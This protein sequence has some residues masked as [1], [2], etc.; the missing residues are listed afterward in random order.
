MGLERAIADLGARLREEFSAQRAEFL[1]LSRGQREELSQALHQSTQAADFKLEAIRSTLLSRLAALETHNS[2]QLEAMRAV[3]DEKL[4]HTLEKRLGDS[5]RLVSERLD[6]V[7]KGLGEM[8]GLASG[9][10][11]LRRLL[12][13]V[14]TRGTWGEFQLAAIL[15]Q[16]LTPE[17]YEANVAVQTG[18]AERVEF[19]IRLPGKGAHA[20]APVLL[21]IDSKF[22]KEDYERLLAAQ[23]AIDPVAVEAASRA[24]EQAVRLAAKNIRTQYIHPPTTTDF[25]IL[26]LPTESLYAEVLRR[27][28]LAEAMQRDYRIALAGPTTLAALLNSLQMGFRTLAIEERSSEVWAILGAVKSEF[29]K[30]GDILEKVQDKL[31]QASSTIE[32]ATKKTRT[33]VRKLR[34]VETLPETDPGEWLE[35]P[36]TPQ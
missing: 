7:H 27:P 34:D 1:N 20:D 25:A 32:D 9:V 28:G 36:R 21:P 31:H 30:F 24:L 23:D 18:S 3:V 29:S 15:E 13:N 10:G 11:D 4:H 12:T 6:L 19:A 2:Q 35:G 8:Q 17:Q 33:I 26:F 16:M 22:P 14:K 5:F